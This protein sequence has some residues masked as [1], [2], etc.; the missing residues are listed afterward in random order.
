MLLG[1]LFYIVFA[2]KL[3]TSVNGA[4]IGEIKF[5]VRLLALTIENIVSRELY[6]FCTDLICD[7]AQIPC[8]ERIDAKGK[9]RLLLAQGSIRNR[10][11]VNDDVR[12]VDLA[13]AQHL[14]GLCDV[15]FIFIRVKD[16]HFHRIQYLV[17]R[18]ADLSGGSG[19][20]YL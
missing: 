16:F 15:E 19:N 2:G 3:G 5:R 18:S 10:S 13:K 4:R 11:A 14:I 12:T 17:D 20:P 7:N 6:K 1:K 9:L 8:A